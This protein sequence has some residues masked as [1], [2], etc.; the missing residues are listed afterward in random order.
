MSLWNPATRSFEGP[1]L[2]RALI[3][4]GYTVD[5]FAKDSGVKHWSL[6]NALKGR[7]VRDETI[8]RLARS[9]SARSGGIPW[10]QN[11]R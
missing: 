10:N 8:E 4:R 5:E 9:S 3:A 6:Y 7:R 2:H 11:A 1:M